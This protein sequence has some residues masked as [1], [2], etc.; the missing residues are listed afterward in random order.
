MPLCNPTCQS[1]WR[2][3]KP[4]P[5]R[6]EG[7]REDLRVNSREAGERGFRRKNFCNRVLKNQ[8]TGGR[9]KWLIRQSAQGQVAQCIGKTQE[10]DHGVC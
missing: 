3:P 6:T 2:G 5:G 4:G 1:S 10:P 9:L 7:R 8:I